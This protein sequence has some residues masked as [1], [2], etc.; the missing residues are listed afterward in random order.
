VVMSIF[1]V[2]IVDLI[3]TAVFFFMGGR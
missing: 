1:M 3:F 2:V